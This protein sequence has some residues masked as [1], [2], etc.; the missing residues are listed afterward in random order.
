[1]KYLSIILLFIC[2]SCEPNQSKDESALNKNPSKASTSQSEISGRKDFLRQLED[3]FN[4]DGSESIYLTLIGENYDTVQINGTFINE[5]FYR[6][7]KTRTDIKS[8][9]RR[10]GFD[11]VVFANGKKEW[12][13][14][15]W[16]E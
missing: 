3:N 12:K 16:N 6:K 2:L 7:F 11:F 13:Y 1:M 4:S 15:L 5:E 14:D 10:E 8:R 9:L